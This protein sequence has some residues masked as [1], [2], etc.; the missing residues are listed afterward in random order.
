MG[1][2][3][4]FGGWFW[5]EEDLEVHGRQE[6]ENEVDRERTEDRGPKKE[7]ENYDNGWIWDG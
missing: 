5:V 1:V 4:W 7:L 2:W 6:I 3:V